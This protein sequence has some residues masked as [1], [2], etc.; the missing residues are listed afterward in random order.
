MK[1]L[2]IV[3]FCSLLMPLG[4]VARWIPDATMQ[5]CYVDNRS[6]VND[7]IAINNGEQIFAAYDDQ[8]VRLWEP[9]RSKVIQ[10]FIGAN[11]AVETIALLKESNQTTLIGGTTAGE[12]V[13]W[14]TECNGSE[15]NSTRR[16]RGHD[17]AIHDIVVDN[18]H[19]QIISASADQ[20]IKVWSPTGELI[21]TFEEENHKAIN[22]IALIPHTSS[23]LF[24]SDDDTIQQWEMEQNRI[25][26]TYRGHTDDVT[27]LAI[28]PDGDYFASGS[29]DNQIKLWS[30]KRGRLLATLK[31]HRSTI[32]DLCFTS[33]G[34]QLISASGSFYGKYDNSIK[35]W[36]L[37]KRRVT[38]TLHGHQDYVN[39][40][41]LSRDGKR[42]FSASDDE[43]IKV[44]SLPKKH[45]QKSLIGN[46]SRVNTLDLSHNGRYLL[47]GSDDHIVRLWDI[48]AGRLLQHFRGESDAIHSVAFSGN[49]RYIVT[50]S[51]SPQGDLG[52]SINLYDRHNQK[53]L[54][55][56]QSNR[57]IYD[58]DVSLGRYIVAA[59]EDSY[60]LKLWDRKKRK[61]LT[62]LHGHMGQ[63]NTVAISWDGTY[64]LSGSDD[65]TLKLWSRKHKKVIH[66]FSG[67]RDAVTGV[68]ITHDDHQIVSASRDKT[69]KIWDRK[70]QS[71]IRTLHTQEPIETMTMTSDGHYIL[72]ASSG[73]DE[74][75]PKRLVLWDAQRGE[76][77]QTF[78]TDNSPILALA[79]SHD[80]KY[81]LSTS[82]ESILLWDRNHPEY[83]I[84]RFV[85]GANNQWV[86]FDYQTHQTHQENNENLLSN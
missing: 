71:L 66:T 54:K 55:S 62:T 1:P 39:A 30:L 36:N 49:E 5:P 46:G 67:H 70:K 78:A 53:R 40:L 9:N 84:K 63:I 2:E 8:M 79:L 33:S 37:K 82:Q 73:L 7:L 10:R 80:G 56:I 29:E 23:L 57:Y 69:I 47:S 72:T 35:I 68:A 19:H 86:V 13:M 3:L 20:T 38:K 18:A 4:L 75:S 41:C 50:G 48:N 22:A 44:W 45:L 27:A 12:I 28:S 34:Q 59:L 6:D 81:I 51:G 74:E 64:L 32:N 83:P 26:Q 25:I 85:G 17:D 31:G 42:L 52:Y 76:A 58:L 16:W 11:A 43:S 60:D 15:I 77:L 61:S 21:K 24:T 14:N 65:H